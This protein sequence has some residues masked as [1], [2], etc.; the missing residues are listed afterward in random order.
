MTIPP[1][2]AKLND[3]RGGTFSRIFSKQGF[4]AEFSVFI[5]IIACRNGKAAMA[6][7]GL[8]F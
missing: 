2:V 7:S 8:A 4:Y 6:G 5:I 3:S 1:A